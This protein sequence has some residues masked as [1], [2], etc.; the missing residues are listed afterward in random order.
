MEQGSTLDSLGGSIVQSRPSSD[1]QRNDYYP[2]GNSRRTY[3]WEMMKKLFEFLYY[4]LYKMFA[5]IKRVG[6]KDENLASFFYSILLSTKTIL[7][8]FFLRYTAAKNILLHYDRIFKISML[9]IFVIWYFVCKYY[10]IKKENYK[11]IVNFYEEEYKGKNKKMAFLGI[12]YSI[13]TFLLFIL[14]S[15]LQSKK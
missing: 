9:M 7:L 14:P 1:L 8:F 10:F 13:C 15:L 12:V 11:K 6:E 5:L 2:I 3:F 4:C